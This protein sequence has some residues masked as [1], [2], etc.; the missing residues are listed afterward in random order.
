MKFSVLVLCA[1]ALFA[2]SDSIKRTVIQRQELST[3][4][5][6]AAVVLVEIVPGG[7]AGR[8][9]HPGDE[10]SYVTQGEFEL[11]V[12]GQAPRN[13]KAGES[14]IIPAGTI[15][16]GHNKGTV[17]VK[18]TGVY[19]LEKGAPVAQPAAR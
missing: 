19:L 10:I 16:D 17:P 9:S 13:I 3:G 4:G 2:Q 14:F 11:I 1:V 5:R 18:F 7:S 6:E 15:H 12:D 8:H